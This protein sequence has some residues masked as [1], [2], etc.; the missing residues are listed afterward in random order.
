MQIWEKEVHPRESL[1]SYMS[2]YTWAISN[3]CW[4]C[5]F[6]FFRRGLYLFFFVAGRY[7][8]APRYGSI[9]N[10]KSNEK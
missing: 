3:A 8:T 2:K 6:S 9:K 4:F 7:A 5:V 10:R 1:R